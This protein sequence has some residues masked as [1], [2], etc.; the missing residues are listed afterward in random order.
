[1]TGFS[2]H[3]SSLSYPIL[4]RIS[5]RNMSTL[6]FVAMSFFLNACPFTTYAAFF[7]TYPHFAEVEGAFKTTHCTWWV[8]TITT[9]RSCAG[10]Q[11]VKILRGQNRLKRNS[12][13]PTKFSDFYE[14]STQQSHLVRHF[15]SL[16]AA[17]I[18]Y[19]GRTDHQNGFIRSD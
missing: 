9:K 7:S 6:A 15:H 10:N 14:E 5:S 12:W 8:V 13:I 4:L 1:M 18:F 19:Q 16:L 11:M 2:V 17:S 3:G